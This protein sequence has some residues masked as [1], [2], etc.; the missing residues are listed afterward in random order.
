MGMTEPYLDPAPRDLSKGSFLATKPRERLINSIE[1]GVPGTS[2]PDW[3]KVLTAQQ[4]DGTLDYVFATFVQDKAAKPIDHHM[5]AA[6]P[7]ADSA[8]SR[9]RGEATFMARCTGCHGKKADGKGPNSIDI[10][11]HPRNLRNA[12]FVHALAD[13]RMLDSI[14]YGVRGTAMPSW[15][16][17]GLSQKD[18]GDLINYIRSLTPAQRLQAPIRTARR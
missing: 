13:Q 16:E 2:M 5:P 11:P 18:A 12:Y 8:E 9:S 15:I 1:D 17:Y 3:G 4:I 14:L 7:V 6:N 10:S